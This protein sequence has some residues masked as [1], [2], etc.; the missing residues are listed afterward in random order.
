[1]TGGKTMT[2]ELE[3][4]AEMSACEAMT[5]RD[6]ATQSMSMKHE[7]ERLRSEN[8]TLR[9]KLHHAC[10][11]GHFDPCRKCEM[12]MRPGCICEACGWDRSEIEGEDE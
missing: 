5:V 11:I 2:S 12:P 8:A 6:W 4:Q 3:I 9:E 10:G 7:I 1:M